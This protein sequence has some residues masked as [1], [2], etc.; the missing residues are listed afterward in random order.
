MKDLNE[1]SIDDLLIDA[2]EAGASDLHIST[3]SRPR[4]R[5]HGK[6]VNMQ[7]YGILQPA[8]VER[9]I[10]NLLDTFARTKLNSE[11]QYDMS[12]AIPKVSRFRVNIFRQKGDIAGVFR[13]LTDTVPEYTKLGMPLG[14]FN[15]YKLRRGL[16]LIVGPTGSG[17]TTTLASFLDVINRNVYKHIITLE[18]PIEYVHWHSRSIVNQREIGTDCSSFA[19]GLR[20]ALREDPDVILI[21]E[22]RDLETTEIALASAETGH[23]V[24]S[25]LHTL[26][27]SETVNRILSMYP[28][29]S[30]NLVRSQLCSILEAVVSQQLLPRAD[31]KGY[32][33]CYE[34]MYKNKAI[35]KMIEQN[36]I[37]DINAYLN[38][39]E[40]INEG[41][42]SMDT[43]IFERLRKKL[44]TRDTALDYAFDRKDMLRKIKLLEDTTSNV[45]T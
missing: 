2:V 3:G 44:I 34:I 12:Y 10:Y 18:D 39:P 38:T 5:I 26:G 45:A 14:L 17:K 8:Q 4:M 33:V 25:T 22:M 16:I 31:E 32:I 11:G 35:K 6:L 23:L 9:M 37:D 43:C 40:A 1:T 28:D 29:S 36:Q 42:I 20:A 15:L 7:D 19:D 41:M 21:G 13:T 24:C 27:A 30:H